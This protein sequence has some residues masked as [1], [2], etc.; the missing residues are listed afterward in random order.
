MKY[1]YCYIS[2]KYLRITYIGGFVPEE[3]RLVGQD[4]G[5]YTQ[6]V[7]AELGDLLRLVHSYSLSLNFLRSLEPLDTSNK[8]LIIT[9]RN[10]YH[11][12]HTEYKKNKKKTQ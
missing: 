4:V 7:V 3:E 11:A 5:Q 10:I 12:I 2:F 8:L 1:L 9:T 6:V